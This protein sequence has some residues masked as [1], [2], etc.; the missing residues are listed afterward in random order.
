MRQRKYRGM[1]LSSASPFDRLSLEVFDVLKTPWTSVRE[2]IMVVEN[3]AFSKHPDTE[4]ML[5]TC[6]ENP[7]STVIVLRNKENQ[8]I[9]GYAY[10]IPDQEQSLEVALI[11]SIALMPSLQ[12]QG[13]GGNITKLLEEQLVKKGYQFITMRA[14]IENGYADKIKKHYDSRIVECREVDSKYGKQSYCKIRL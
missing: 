8:K 5:R 4:E 6:F 12:G 2:D 13:L 9:V 1:S 10:A 11:D 14:R 3:A 7:S